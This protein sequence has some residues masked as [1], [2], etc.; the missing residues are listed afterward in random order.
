MK[1]VNRWAKMESEEITVMLGFAI[2]MGLAVHEIFFVLALLVV[3]IA[4][5]QWTF[6]RAHE[7][8]HDLYLQPR[9]P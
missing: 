1:K 5:G 2:G 7:R 4:V 6:E 8:L 3:A 9:H